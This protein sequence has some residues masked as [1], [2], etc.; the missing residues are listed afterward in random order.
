MLLVGRKG[1]FLT[2]EIVQSLQD[3]L[4]GH[5][6]VHDDC[7]AF[8]LRISVR[9]YNE[10]T[11]SS[12]KGT[13]LG[14]KSH[15]A[16][17]QPRSSEAY[18]SSLIKLQSEIK[19]KEEERKVSSMVESVPLWCRLPT[20]GNVTEFC[21]QLVMA[22]WLHGKSDYHV[23]RTDIRHVWKVVAA[24]NKADSDIIPAFRH[25]C[26]V[27][28]DDKQRVRCFCKHFER[29]GYPCRHQAAVFQVEDFAYAGFTHHDCSIQWWK[30]FVHHG[31]RGTPKTEEL[32]VVLEQ[33]LQIDTTFPE[34]LQVMSK[35]VGNNGRQ[36][37]MAN[38][39]ETM[40]NYKSKFKEEDAT[41]M[42]KN[43]LSNSLQR[44]LDMF[45][46]V[47]QRNSTTLTLLND[48]GFCSQESFQ[49][50]GSILPPF[51]PDSNMSQQ[52]SQEIL[53]I[54]DPLSDDEEPTE[55]IIQF[56]GTVDDQLAEGD[57]E[58]T[59]QALID[60]IDRET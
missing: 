24:D 39:D 53:A 3:F 36:P 31:L 29:C 16:A 21:H 7:F 60:K 56:R 33:M 22:N 18:N 43:F 4:V 2:H 45:A 13:N 8:H 40:E 50:D 47:T 34:I 30:K 6:F 27:T 10:A 19:A 23:L 52:L 54:H 15:H 5:V 12:H 20:G 37:G 11:N 48:A 1:G 49:D 9:S 41:L 32:D 51:P 28:V 25:V 38:R 26:T 59:T 55:P 14:L 58:D 42:C 57:S 17:I 46:S 44:A 35:M